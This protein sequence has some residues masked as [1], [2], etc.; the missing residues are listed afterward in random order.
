[1]GAGAENNAVNAYVICDS[2]YLEKGNCIFIG[3]KTLVITYQEHDFYSNDS[4]NLILRLKN[5]DKA[6]KLVQLY[7]ISC[8]YQSLRNKY[9]W[10]NSISYKKIQGDIV[11]LPTKNGAIDFDFMES[12]VAELEAERVA[13]LSVYLEAS[14]LKDYKLTPEE[15][16]AVSN[17][18]N[19]RWGEFKLGE[20]FESSNGNYDIQKEHIN[21][22]GDYVI[23]SG[24]LN[25]GVL[26]KTD[27]PAKI[28]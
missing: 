28:F 10:G 3:G 15:E 2:K 6:T 19:V 5:Q 20:L 18:K 27:I 23:T 16:I 1:M 8:I 26:G 12:F 4:H 9:S 17:L 13:E 22:I 21:G 25:N 14:G 7:L 24:L 11:Q